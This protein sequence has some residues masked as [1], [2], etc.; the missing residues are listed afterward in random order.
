M[1]GSSSVP[2]PGKA[3]APAPV[4]YQVFYDD[5]SPYGD[6]IDY[7]GYGYVWSPY[8]NTGG[9]FVP[10]CSDGNWIY[11]DFGWTWNS[12]FNWG[13]GPFH[14]GRWFNDPLYGWLWVPGYDWAPAWVAW[15][16]YDNYYCWAPLGPGYL[17]D[18]DDFNSLHSWTF[19]PEKKFTSSNLSKVA[20]RSDK[21][22]SDNI[23]LIKNSG[24]F[25][26]QTFYNG[27]KSDEIEKVT[28]TKLNQVSITEAKKPVKAKIE[29]NSV[30]MYRPVIS[31]SLTV[32]SKPASFTNYQ[33][34]KLINSSVKEIK[35]VE[36]QKTTN[37]EHKSSPGVIVE[38]NTGAKPI[39]KNTQ[40]VSTI[41]EK[42]QSY[43]PVSK[44]VYHNNSSQGNYKSSNYN[45]SPS[46]GSRSSYSHGSVSHSY[47][48]GN[49]S[50]NYNNHKH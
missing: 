23:I 17:F 18:K 1:P 43:S 39:S 44:Q 29:N 12:E 36:T 32:K 9:E 46:T 2:V 40:P 50:Y 27:P 21:L 7:S 30:S 15:G 26:G 25:N 16:F 24:K 45:Y 42:K 14:Y 31:K 19:V 35:N 34:E 28:G 33:N 8:L 47:N 3:S 5:L 20:V 22:N 13:W 38:K 11:T 48:S 4:S 10:Y 37:A 49:N 41:V 6:W